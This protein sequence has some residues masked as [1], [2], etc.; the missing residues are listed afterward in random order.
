MR[1]S[2]DWSRFVL[3]T[4]QLGLSYGRRSRQPVLDIGTVERIL[5]AAWD[6][7]I[8]AFDTAEAYGEAPCRLADWLRQRGRT[9]GA[10]VVTKVSMHDAGNLQSLRR[11]TGRFEGI[12]SLTLLSHE[13]MLPAAFE[14][15]KEFAESQGY[16][17]GQSVYTAEEVGNAAEAGAARVQAPL[18]TLD[19]RQLE[20]AH[21]A[22]IA[23]DGRSIYLQGLL[24]ETPEAAERRVPG[25]AELAAAVQSAA[26]EAGLPP[27]VA[28][29]AAAL[30]RLG[31]GD[32]IVIGIDSPEQVADLAAAREVS[33]GV[34]EGF[35]A[36]LAMQ[37]KRAE[38]RPHLFDPRMWPAR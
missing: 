10:S 15:L 23:F 9:D 17:P 26:G 12:A 31:P 14:M 13:V 37:A 4:V 5:D 18:N 25:G 11:A 32:R 24:L 1:A 20:A 21:T 27:A 3:G 38:G 7:G 19:R 6:A 29:C 33:R 22:G 30:A 2:R 34:V 35:A 8:R 36:T 28:L 16:E